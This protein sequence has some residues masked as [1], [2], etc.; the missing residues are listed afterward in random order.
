MNYS[1]QMLI[2]QYLSLAMFILKKIA[3]EY[4]MLI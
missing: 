2:L 3:M 4:C 1:Y